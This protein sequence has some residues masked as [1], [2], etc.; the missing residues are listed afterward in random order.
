MRRQRLSLHVQ[1]MFCLMFL[2]QASWAQK[3]S[4]YQP[5]SFALSLDPGAPID[6]YTGEII[7]DSAAIQQ[8]GAKW[9]RINFIVNPWTGPSD[10]SR[11]GSLNLTWFEVYDRIVNDAIS[12]GLTIYGLVS[13]ESVRSS[14]NYETDGYIA[15]YTANFVAIVGHFKDRVRVYESFNEPNNWAFGPYP[16]LG[17]YY[18]AKLLE[19]V[20]R[21]VKIDNGHVMD[22]SWNGVTLLS[23]PLFT[24]DQDT[25]GPYFTEVINAGRNQLGWNSLKSSYGT[26]PFDG[27]GYHLY[28]TGGTD[29]VSQVTS[30]MDSNINTFWNVITGLEGGGTPKRLWVSETGWNTKDV[31]EAVQSNNVETVIT[32]AKADIRVTFL[33]W[34][35]LYD[36]DSTNQWGLARRDGYKKAGWTRYQTVAA[37]VNRTSTP[38]YSSSPTR[39]RTPTRTLTPLQTATFTQTRTPTLT[40]IPVLSPTPAHCQGDANGDLF[41]NTEDFRTVR[42]YFGQNRCG[43]GDATGDC[44]VNTDDFRAVRDHFG[45]PCPF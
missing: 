21:A 10:S 41:V 38:T 19:N 35:C 25:G 30:K 40:P 5:G 24:H 45:Q 26:Y 18:F 28:T 39:T 11:H 15:D 33:S 1:L 37:V 34:F 6:A 43:L 2:L 20:Y 14:Y 17:A 29:N 13:A 4:V 9:V 8:S 31:S 36:W 23:G 12:R 42:D 44:F 16:Q 22:P 27:M 32:H 7:F 3:S